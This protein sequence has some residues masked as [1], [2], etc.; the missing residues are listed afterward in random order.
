MYASAF[1]RISNFVFFGEK[2]QPVRLKLTCRVPSPSANSV[3]AIEVNGHSV[4]QESATGAWQNLE[5]TVP[6]QFV[7]EG[8]N[9]IAIVWPDGDR[10]SKVLLEKAAEAL[11]ARR[12]PYF[13]EIF[14]EIHS[15]TASD[16]S[17]AAGA[18]H[19]ATHEAELVSG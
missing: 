16:P 14:A 8:M 10:D 4:A 3:V 2:G 18:A 7:L 13:H 6:G 9:E 17:W 11:V 5:A 19:A 15:L 1:S 12:L